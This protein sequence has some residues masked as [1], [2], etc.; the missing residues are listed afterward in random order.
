MRNNLIKLGL[1]IK[2]IRKDK[3]LPLRE[4]ASRAGLSVSL[5]SKVE[6]FRT[7]PSLPVLLS[8]AEAMNVSVADL[9]MDLSVETD[10]RSYVLTRR[11]DREAV[12]REDGSGYIYEAL[13]DTSISGGNF[14][15]FLLSLVP[16]ATREAVSTEGRQ[17]LYCLSREFEFILGEE[18]ILLKEGDLLFFDGTIPHFSRNESG[19][20][21]RVLAGYFID[22]L[23]CGGN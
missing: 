17:F 21:T 10:Q 13:L 9:V 11:D 23:L 3:G 19:E 4:I 12:E 5:I 18:T 14:Q 20:V 22:D 7:V 2:R 15:M 1:T 16:G 6:N 8:I